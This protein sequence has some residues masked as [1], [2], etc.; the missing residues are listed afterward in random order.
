ML[1]YVIQTSFSFFDSLDDLSIKHHYPAKRN[2]HSLNQDVLSECH[3]GQ[4]PYI[5]IL[6]QS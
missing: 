2:E 6:Y 3:G 4:L 1:S 5:A